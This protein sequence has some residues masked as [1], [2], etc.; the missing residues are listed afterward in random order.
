LFNLTSQH[1]YDTVQLHA[2]PGRYKRHLLLDYIGVSR[3]MALLDSCSLCHAPLEESLVIVTR[4]K[5]GVFGDL[6]DDLVG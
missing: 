6:V 4:R 1:V 3:S 2:L 5:R